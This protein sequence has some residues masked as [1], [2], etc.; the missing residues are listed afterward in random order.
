MRQGA[1]DTG[2]TAGGGRKKAGGWG[3]WADRWGRKEGGR[4]LGTLG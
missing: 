3:H 2:L 4:G 1:G